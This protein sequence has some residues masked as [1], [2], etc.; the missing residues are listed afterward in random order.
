[1]TLHTRIRHQE[2]ANAT[3]LMLQALPCTEE[4]KKNVSPSLLALKFLVF[5][6]T[7]LFLVRAEN[8]GPVNRY[9]TRH[10]PL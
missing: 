10:P 6:L 5:R 1:M 9:Y 2:R 3:C 8:K 4:Q 7:L